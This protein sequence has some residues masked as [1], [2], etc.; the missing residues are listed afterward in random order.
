M[1]GCDA[2]ER[3]REVVTDYPCGLGRLKA[4]TVV[5]SAAVESWR[6]P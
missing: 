1:E 6:I 2:A 5:N 3:A 4:L